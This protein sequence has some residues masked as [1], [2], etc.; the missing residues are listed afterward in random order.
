[1]RLA[2][3]GSESHILAPKT[4][5]QRALAFTLKGLDDPL[6]SPTDY[7]AGYDVIS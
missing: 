4:A 7:D 5:V 6:M 2:R 3:D 1:M